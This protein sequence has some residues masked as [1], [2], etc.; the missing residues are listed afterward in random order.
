MIARST[1][2]A[3]RQR[4]SSDGCTFSQ[5]VRSSS[6]SGIS[7]PYAATTIA[8]ASGSSASAG[9][10]GWSTGI[11]SRSATSFAGGGPTRRPRPRGASGRVRRNATSSASASR[12]STSA[13]R[14]A[15]AATPMRTDGP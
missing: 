10:S 11:P 13:P 7:S 14:G 15:V 8:S 9:R 2:A 4:G 5:S 1:G 3:P 6:D 12:S